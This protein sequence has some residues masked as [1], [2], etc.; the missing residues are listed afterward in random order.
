MQFTTLALIP[1]PSCLPLPFPHPPAPSH[2][3]HKSSNHAPLNLPYPIHKT[4][5]NLFTLAQQTLKSMDT[6]SGHCLPPRFT[7]SPKL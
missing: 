7:L 2:P 3:T 6:R 4:K 1:I 5:P